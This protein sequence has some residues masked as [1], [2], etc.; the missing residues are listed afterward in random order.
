MAA[1]SATA[2]TIGFAGSAEANAW[3]FYT[4]V[5]TDP[6][7]AGSARLEY[8]YEPDGSGAYT[9][10]VRGGGVTSYY[11]D[12][13]GAILRMHDGSATIDKWK[14]VDAGTAGTGSVEYPGVQSVWFEVCNYN[15]STNATYSCA[16]LRKE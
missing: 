11:S 1:A 13:H 2:L 6:A 9:A 15:L 8:R 10:Y 14:T 4:A 7:A 5:T 12:G 3:A 16:R